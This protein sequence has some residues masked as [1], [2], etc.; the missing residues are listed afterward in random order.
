MIN[1]E[2]TEKEHQHYLP[3]FS[4]ISCR[5]VAELTCNTYSELMMKDI[6]SSE[7]TAKNIFEQLLLIL[8][9]MAMQISWLLT[10]GSIGLIQAN[11]TN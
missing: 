10:Q 1:Q 4:S 3:G 11:N 5:A 2:R 6:W 8:K 9:N 7:A